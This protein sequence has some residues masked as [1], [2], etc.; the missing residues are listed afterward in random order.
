MTKWHGFQ[1]NIELVKMGDQSNY[2]FFFLTKK[3]KEKKKQNKNQPKTFACT[4]N[5]TTI[6]SFKSSALVDLVMTSFLKHDLTFPLTFLLVYRNHVRWPSD[7]KKSLFQ[8]KVKPSSKSR[9]QLWK[10]WKRFGIVGCR[11]SLSF[12]LLSIVDLRY[13]VL[14]WLLRVWFH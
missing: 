14:L 13:F 6:K 5:L 7:W 2:L 9:S 8:T 10:E 4:L 1:P 12:I 11:G 3:R